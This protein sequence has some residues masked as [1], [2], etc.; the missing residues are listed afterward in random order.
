MRKIVNIESIINR[1]DRENLYKVLYIG[2]SA[3]SRFLKDYKELIKS[4]SFSEIKT[5]LLNFFIKRQF[6]DDILALDF[7]YKAELKKVNNFNQRAIFLKNNKTKIQ[8][9]KTSKRNRFFNGIKPAQYMLKEARLNSIYS[10]EIK[11]FIDSDDE[12]KVKEDRRV[13]MILGYGI[14]GEQ[15]DHLEFIIPN[16]Y[17]DS[18][19]DS[20]DGL[21]EYNEMIVGKVN[22]EVV[23]ERIVAL[24]EEALKLLIK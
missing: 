19:I 13:F 14:K 22:D 18:A 21:D 7:P 4:E 23:E 11:F 24:K 10:N 5:R 20:F 15:M 8:V 12:V 1:A 3:Y 16:E 6:E 9:N 17:M 2:A